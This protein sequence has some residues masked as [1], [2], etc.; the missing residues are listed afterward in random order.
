V[1]SASDY[2]ELHRAVDRLT[3]VQAEALYTMLESMFGQDKPARPPP[4][5]APA[6]TP[7]YSRIIEESVDIA[8]T[9][10]HG[11]VG[12]EH[13]FLAI[14]RD[15]DAV[16]SQSLAQQIDLSEV[17]SHLLELLNSPAYRTLPATRREDDHPG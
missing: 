13:L 14:I 9:M 17:E 7:R 5:D 2:S 3:P 11:Y 15:R 16:P 4:A 12:V 6:P 10:V 1:T 8:S